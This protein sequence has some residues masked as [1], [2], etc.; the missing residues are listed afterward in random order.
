MTQGTT[1]TLGNGGSTGATSGVAGEGTPGTPGPPGA[2]DDLDPS[3]DLNGNALRLGL[4]MQALESVD[5]EQ[6]ARW[7]SMAHTLGPVLDPTKYRDALYRGDM[8]DLAEL[9]RLLLPAVRHWREKIAPKLEG[10]DGD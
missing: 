1:G 7:V 10:P 8:D 2:L 6:I 4:V 5:L 9:A 3:F